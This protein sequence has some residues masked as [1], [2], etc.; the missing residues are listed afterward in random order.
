MSSE[1]QRAHDGGETLCLLI[2]FS[3]NQQS[4]K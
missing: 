4:M 3:F 2:P 1:N